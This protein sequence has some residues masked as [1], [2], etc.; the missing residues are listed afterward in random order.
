DEIFDMSR[1]HF[2]VIRHLMTNHEWDYFQFVEIGLDRVHHGFWQYFDPQHVLYEAGNPYENVIP[3]YYRH[4][5]EEIGRLLELVD[6]DTAI[7][8]VSDHGAQRLDGGFC[9]N[10]WLIRQGLLVLN[11]YP[12]EITPFSKLDVDWSRTRVWSEGGYYARVFFNVRG[13]EP[14]GVIDP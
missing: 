8:I 14:Q 3:D 6:D 4:L 2:E 5:D 12:A 1:K 7:A 9:V 11:E 13:R 10:E